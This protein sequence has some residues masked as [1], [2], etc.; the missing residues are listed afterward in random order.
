MLDTKCLLWEKLHGYIE[1]KVVPV[2]ERMTNEAGYELLYSPSHYS[3]FQPI[4][5][6][7]AIVKGDV[8]RQY[9][10]DTTLKDVLVRLK[11]AFNNLQ[12]HTVQGCIRKA[13]GKLIK[14]EEYIQ[15]KE[16]M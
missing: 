9:T 3:D 5:T 12:S 2:V 6:V 13:K 10:T 16:D 1:R 7:W 8:G 4:E 15:Q 11:A 14:L